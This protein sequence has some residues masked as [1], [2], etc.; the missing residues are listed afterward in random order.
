MSTQLIGF[1]MGGAIKRFLVSPPSMSPCTI[2]F[3]LSSS[4]SR[5]LM[6]KFGQRTLSHVHFLILYTP[7]FIRVFATRESVVSAFSSL[8]S[9]LPASGVCSSFF[10]LCP[11]NL[12]QGIFP[13]YLFT[14]L[15][16]FSWVGVWS[17]QLVHPFIYFY[18]SGDMD[19]AT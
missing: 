1:S 14:A 5:A 7:K 9:S 2:V 6:M 12:L 17:A 4:N 13:G 18:D 11:T 19:L 10:A 3:G 16:T 8:L 15:S